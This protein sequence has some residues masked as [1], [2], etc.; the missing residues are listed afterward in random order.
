MKQQTLANTSKPNAPPPPL[1]PATET[2]TKQE[3]SSMNGTVNQ[4]RVTSKLVVEILFIGIVFGTNEGFFYNKLSRN[5]VPN[6]CRIPPMLLFFSGLSYSAESLIECEL[7]A[8][9]IVGNV[10]KNQGSPRAFVYF[11]GN[12]SRSPTSTSYLTSPITKSPLDPNVS[13]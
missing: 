11:S 2:P 4:M 10:W 7:I 12:V 9:Y 8:F 6:A 5:D 3:T 13:A 1:I